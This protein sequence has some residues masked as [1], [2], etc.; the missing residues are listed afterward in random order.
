MYSSFLKFK[1]LAVK[2]QKEDTQTINHIYKIEVLSYPKPIIKFLNTPDSLYSGIPKISTNG[3]KLSPNEFVPVV[4]IL[5]K[6]TQK[7]IIILCTI[8][9]QPKL[10]DQ[11]NFFLQK[12]T[13]EVII[14]C[15]INEIKMTNILS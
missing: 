6:S 5:L 12:N 1:R 10:K 13:I 14:N 8:T 11:S 2:R 7:D 9:F 4:D 15:T 3:D